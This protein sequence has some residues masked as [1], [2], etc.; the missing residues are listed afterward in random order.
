[1]VHIRLYSRHDLLALDGAIRY[2]SYLIVY[3]HHFGVVDFVKFGS[4]P[5]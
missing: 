2:V 1:M 5:A 4:S 3:V